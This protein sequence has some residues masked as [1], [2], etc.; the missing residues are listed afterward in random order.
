MRSVIKWLT[1]GLMVSTAWALD[2]PGVVGTISNKAGGEIVF[3][4]EAC[5]TDETRF[6]VFIRDKGGKVSNTGCW[7]FR[8]GAFW[9]FYGDGDVFNYPYEAIKMTPEFRQYLNEQRGVKS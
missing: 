4:G 1:V 3:T 9:V 6:F 7:V 8:Q 5:P 2:W